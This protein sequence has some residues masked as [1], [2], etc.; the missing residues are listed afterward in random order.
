MKSLDTHEFVERSIKYS[1]MSCSPFCQPF[2]AENWGRISGL[3]PHL[4]Q[5]ES[6]IMVI[7]IG[8]MPSSC[9]LSSGMRKR[10]TKE[11][12]LTTMRVPSHQRRAL[13]G[14]EE[15]IRNVALRLF[16]QKGFQATGIREI[17]AEAGLTI[18]ALYY[19][20]GTKEELLLDILRDTA[21][22]MLASALPIGDAP[23]PPERK[24]ALLVLLHVWFSGEHAQQ[25]QV[26]NTELRS[27]S[28]T[29][30]QL[31]LDLRDRY[32]AIWRN[33]IEQGD[34][35]GIFQVENA[36]LAAIA[37]IEMCNGVSYWFR[38]HGPLTLTQVCYM[39]ADWA[40]GLV[41]AVRDGKPVRVAD[42]KLV[43]PQELYLADVAST[44]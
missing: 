1:I 32:E 33:V 26:A 35:A 36:K 37:V 17:A 41:R 18:S 30:R 14:T 7:M 39:H 4:S 2:Y 21:T 38:S 20:L 13:N 9:A 31:V 11:S 44:S 15:R 6:G 40:L 19:Y 34:A 28:G 24:L 16:A 29:A 23:D 27:L 43:D 8:R 25:M 10:S 5:D 42:L 3:L 12:F 22:S